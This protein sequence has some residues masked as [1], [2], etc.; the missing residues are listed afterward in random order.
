[1]KL[2]LA[3]NI[4]DTIT[5]QSNDYIPI[6]NFYVLDFYG[7]ANGT[8]LTRNYNLT[9]IQNLWLRLI[10]MQVSYYTDTTQWLREAAYDNKVFTN[11]GNQRFALTRPKMKINPN[12]LA[13]LNDSANTGIINLLINGN[14]QNI[15]P[16]ANMPIIENLDLNLLPG[17]Q[18]SS[19]ID[20]NMTYSFISDVDANTT[21]NPYVH[22]LLLVQTYLQNPQTTFIQDVQS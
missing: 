9:S 1:M 14:R 17:Y 21:A 15:F 2:R 3:D 5:I 16:S 4:K 18:I 19:G 13:Q 8:N 11:N 6:Q 10:S 7:Q 12:W 22:V 20:I